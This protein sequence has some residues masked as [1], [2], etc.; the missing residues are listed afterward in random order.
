METSAADYARWHA[1]EPV[2]EAIEEAFDIDGLHA[3]DLTVLA[4]LYELAGPMLGRRPLRVPSSW[5]TQGN[6]SSDDDHHERRGIVHGRGGI[7][8]LWSRGILP[9]RTCEHLIDTGVWT[10]KQFV[11][12]YGSSS[13][14]GSGA[15]SL[16]ELPA[17]GRPTEAKIRAELAR[18]EADGV[19]EPLGPPIK[20]RGWN[21]HAF[22]WDPAL[23]EC[24]IAVV[25]GPDGIGQLGLCV[26]TRNSLIT[27]AQVVAI[28]DLQRLAANDEQL[29]GIGGIGPGSV[30]EIRQA[31][32]AHDAT[33]T[34]H[35][36]VTT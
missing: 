26:R 15:R 21:A 23:R 27:G 25:D 34:I 36:E 10:V 24:I 30:A 20:C 5:T 2:L 12:L 6:R 13:A 35:E 3:T 33:Q 29:L 7:A 16:C 14:Y 9:Y 8:E 22:H 32:A 11:E 4:S 28:S 17:V 18:L 19:P 1:F 31:L